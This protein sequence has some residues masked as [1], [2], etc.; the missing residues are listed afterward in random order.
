MKKLRRFWPRA[1][2]PNLLMLRPPRPHSADLWYWQHWHQGQLLAQGQGWP[3]ETLR[4]LQ[5]ALVIPAPCCAHFELLAPVGLRP[6]EW[7]QVLEDQLLQEPD[8]IQI[9]CFGHQQQRLHLAVVNQELLQDWQQGMQQQGLE[10]SY[11]WTEFLLLPEP[12][13][14]HDLYWS[15]E[16][17]GCYLMQD[18]QGV[19][20]RLTWPADQPWP[21]VSERPMQR[22]DSTGILPELNADRLS[23]LL[24]RSQSRTRRRWMMPRPGRAV[25]RLAALCAGLGLC[26]LLLEGYALYRQTQ[27]WRAQVVQQLGTV[28]SSQ[29]AQQRLQ[30]LLRSQHTEQITQQVL[31]EL[32]RSWGDWLS[33]QS[34]WQ[35]VESRFNGRVWQLTVSGSQPPTAEL[36]ARWQSL[37]KALAVKLGVQ[38]QPQEQAT[39]VR[40]S[41]DLDSAEGA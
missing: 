4:N 40:L 15:T 19:R 24:S 25:Q 16:G 38:V 31:A 7:P 6:H 36:S 5:C 26:A 34:E 23:Y 21:L 13:T 32:E 22:L 3:P 18:A 1:P 10:L 37:A 33:R 39:Q 17:Y 11:L 9:L 2:L 28:V 30:P 12:T 35:L 14:E 27:V 41:F 8:Q 29:Q 20:Q